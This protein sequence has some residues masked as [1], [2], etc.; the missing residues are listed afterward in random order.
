[1]RLRDISP[2]AWIGMALILVNLGMFLFGPVL[3]P[4]GQEETVGV[5][6]G[7][8]RPIIFSASTRTGATCCRGYSTARACRS[9]CRL[10]P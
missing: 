9:A 3:A 5:P 8:P 1:M 4:F 2:T 10:P 6:F 7:R